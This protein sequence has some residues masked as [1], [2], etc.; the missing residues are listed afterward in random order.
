MS[1]L[2]QQEGTAIFIG[3]RCLTGVAELPYVVTHIDHQ[4]PHMHITCNSILASMHI[5][6]VLAWV[7]FQGRRAR[8]STFN[9]HHVYHVDSHCMRR[10]H[11]HALQKQYH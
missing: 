11:H 1:Q 3:D 8:K 6:L 9:P 7:Y 10:R 4:L 5:I 2:S